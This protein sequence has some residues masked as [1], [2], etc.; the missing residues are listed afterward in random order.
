MSHG[1]LSFDNVT[2]LRYSHKTLFLLNSFSILLSFQRRYQ[3]KYFCDER[4]ESPRTQILLTMILQKTWCPIPRPTNVISLSIWPKVLRQLRIYVTDQSTRPSKAFHSLRPLLI[5][6]SSDLV[7]YYERRRMRSFS[8]PR[9]IYLD[10]WRTG[11]GTLFLSVKDR[12]QVD[13]EIPEIET[14]IRR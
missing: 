4:G 7:Y 9:R 14:L 12:E 8:F 5:L 6:F 10:R 11:F 3:T 1:E 13:N 2:T